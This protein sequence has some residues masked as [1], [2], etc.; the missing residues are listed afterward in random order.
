VLLFL[1]ENK[2]ALFFNYVSYAYAE[3]GR[4]FFLSEK[5]NEINSNV[6]RV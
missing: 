6:M 3:L 2:I 4:A 5:E 1:V